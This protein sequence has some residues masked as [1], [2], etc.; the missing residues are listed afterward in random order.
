MAPL[1]DPYRVLGLR[2]SASDAEVQAAF[3]RLARRH[4]P[5]LNGGSMDAARRFELVHQA[6]EEIRRA[7]SANGACAAGGA[8]ATD[9][10]AA[11][12]RGAAATGATGAELDARLAALEQEVRRT[13]AGRGDTARTDPGSRTGR[14]DPWRSRTGA[15]R[16][17]SDEELGYYH[18]D[19]SLLQ[20]LDDAAESL[21]RRL[22]GSDQAP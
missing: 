13:A 11:A 21:A 3:R 9:G 18:T 16:R 2:T 7:R 15:P 5:D 14:P 19:D 22:T 8:A 17:P 20:I 6:Y 1:A 4:H 10:V 12:A